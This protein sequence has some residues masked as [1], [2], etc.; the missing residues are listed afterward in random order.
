MKKLLLLFIF[1]TYSLAAGATIRYQCV[2]EPYPV[3]NKLSGVVNTLT[4]ANFLGRKTVERDSGI[5]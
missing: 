3:G 2:P 5:F 1:L 4:G